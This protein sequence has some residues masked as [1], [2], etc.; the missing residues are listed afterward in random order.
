MTPPVIVSGAVSE[1][2]PLDVTEFV[3][4]DATTAR[5]GELATPNGSGAI[6]G[7]VLGGVVGLGLCLALCLCIA[8]RAK[9]KRIGDAPISAEALEARNATQ[10]APMPPID[11]PV[12]K[13]VQTSNHYV[14]RLPHMPPIDRPV[15]KYVEARHNYSD[16]RISVK[17][18]IDLTNRSYGAQALPA[19]NMYTDIDGRPDYRTL[20]LSPF[21]S[22]DVVQP[23]TASFTSAKGSSYSSPDL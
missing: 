4:D 13:Y 18:T 6:I 22:Y 15:T 11:Q 12:T 17:S 8:K 3:G 5:G 19:P 10:L 23:E 16:G 2:A 9:N 7:G 14:E 21:P 1:S 20:Q